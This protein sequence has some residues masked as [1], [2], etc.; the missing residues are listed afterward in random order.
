MNYKTS[1]IIFSIIISL[2]LFGEAHCG[3]LDKGKELL[4]GVSSHA[5]KKSDELSVSE[6][7]GGLKD[8]LRVGTENVVKRL[9]TTNGFLKNR[10]VHIPL[11]EKLQKIK[12]TLNRIGMGS[13]LNN[14]ET[15]LNRAA[16]IAT[17]KAKKLFFNAISSMTIDDVKRIYKGPEDAA[18][19][20]FKK[21]MT[22]PLKKEMKPVIDESLN[23]VEAVRVYNSILNKYNSLPFV[24]HVNG[25][26]VDYTLNK[27]L[28][29]I[30]YYLAKEE[31]SIRKNPIKRT[32]A[33][34]KKVFGR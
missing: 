19:Q 5:I 28:D 9:G 2:S 22:L 34:L 3:W 27:T 31:A 18:T 32:T 25:D 29:G 1:I 4:R 8:A 24:T 12:N 13:T 16:E 30:F 17:P 20:Y 21:K 23:Q 6:I 10:A 7:A 33:L 11:P 15:K 14:L 26:I